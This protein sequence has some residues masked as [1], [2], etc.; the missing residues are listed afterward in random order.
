[1]N[2]LAAGKIVLAAIA[3]ATCMSFFT[4]QNSSFRPQEP[5]TFWGTAS[6]ALTFMEDN[7]DLTSYNKNDAVVIANALDRISDIKRANDEAGLPNNS[8][9][10]NHLYQGLLPAFDEL[11]E[12]QNLSRND[13]FR[14]IT[15]QSFKSQYKDWLTFSLKNI[16]HVFGFGLPISFIF[17][18]VPAV[19]MPY[20][21]IFFSPVLS[22]LFFAICIAFISRT[23]KR[24]QPGVLLFFPAVFLLE[25]FASSTFGVPLSRYIR[26]TESFVLIFMIYAFSSL[27]SRYELKFRDWDNDS[28]V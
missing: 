8:Q 5:M 18:I 14:S 23:I 7:P 27:G 9:N 2:R 13:V 3:F 21:T 20:S 12:E 19:Q 25:V 22:L 6:I 15:F 1:L 4:L 16:F 11:L 24:E 26:L 17:G 28:S 10:L